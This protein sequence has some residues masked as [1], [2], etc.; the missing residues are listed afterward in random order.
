MIIKKSFDYEHNDE[1]DSAYELSYKKSCENSASSESVLY[2]HVDHGNIFQ[3][4]I[5]DQIQDICG[6]AT[7][8]MISDSKFDPLSLLS[9]S[10]AQVLEQIVNENGTVTHIIISN[11]L[12]KADEYLNELENCCFLEKVN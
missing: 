6:P 11:L 1:K 8:K 9:N 2:I 12:A 5:G 7:I 3:L 10:Q 4:E